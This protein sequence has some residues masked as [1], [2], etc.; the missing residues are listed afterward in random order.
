MKLPSLSVLRLSIYS[1]AVSTSVLAQD[2]PISE[3]IFA[4]LTPD[5]A[6]SP[7]DEHL[8]GDSIDFN[9]GNV[10]FSN[11]DLVAKGTGIDIVVSRSLVGT[12]VRYTYASSGN[13]KDWAINIPAVHVTTAWNSNND[14]SGSWGDS[15]ECSGDPRE[16]NF[17]EDN[18]SWSYAEYFNGVHLTLDTGS[19]EPVLL[20]N[21]SYLLGSGSARWVTKS[22]WKFSCGS[23]STGESFVGTAPNGLIYTFAKRVDVNPRILE[24]NNELITLKESRLL[25]TQITDRFNNTIT[26]NY[27]SN[28]NVT[29]ITAS[30]GRTITFS[31]SGAYVD[32]MTYNGRIWDYNYSTNSLTEVVQPDGTRYQYNLYDYYRYATPPSGSHACSDA[33]PSD[34]GVNVRTSSFTGTVTG[35]TGVTGTY[36]FARLKHGRANVDSTDT[37]SGS[38]VINPCFSNFGLTK[39]ILSI[40]GQGDKTWIYS[41]SQNAGFFAGYTPSSGQ[42]LNASNLPSGVDNEDYRMT[43]VTAP[44][45]TQ[46][47]YFYNRDFTSFN[48]G[49]L[50]ATQVYDNGGSIVQENI[51]TYTQSASFGDDLT[52]YDNDKPVRYRANTTKT[53]LERDNT[54][55]TTNYSSY[56]K[57]GNYAYKNEFMTGGNTKYWHYTFVNDTTNWLIGQEAKTEISQ[58]GSTYATA[59]KIGYYGATHTY[60][61]LPYITYRFGVYQRVN[62]AYHADGQLKS[63]TVNALSNNTSGSTAH[64]IYFFY[65]YHRG[66]P[67]RIRPYQLYESGV[68][69][70]AN[71]TVDDNGWVTQSKDFEGNIINYTYDDMGRVQTI[72]PVNSSWKDTL[73]DWDFNGSHPKLT[74]SRCT[75]NSAKTGCGGTASYQEVTTYDGLLNPELIART[76][77]VSSTTRYTNFI[78]DELSQKQFESFPSTSSTQSSGTTYTYDVLGR[79][80]TET[81]YG[82]GTVSYDYLSGNRTRV[83]DG[84]GNSTTTTYLAYGSPTKTHAMLIESPE[85]VNTTLTYNIYDNVT[86]ITQSGNHKSTSISITEQRAYNAQQRLCKV[87]RPDTGVSIYVYNNY[88]D[89]TYTAQGVTSSDATACSYS[90]AS[91]ASYTYDNL[92]L[93]HSIDY[94]DNTTPDVTYMRNKNGDLVTLESDSVIHNYTYNSA[95]LMTSEVLTVNSKTFTLSYGY[96]ALGHLSSMTYPGSTVGTVNFAPNGFGEPTKVTRSGQNYVTGATYYPDG[97]LNYFAYPNDMKHKQY[98]NSSQL[99]SQL[100]YYNSTQS[101]VYFSYTYDDNFN[102]DSLTDN[103]NNDYNLNSLSYDGLDRLI[104]VDGGNLI[105]DSTINYDALGNIEYYSSKSAAFTY[106]Y[107]LST[108]RLSDISGTGSGLY[109]FGANGSYDTRGNILKNGKRS[110]NYNRANQL[111]QSSTIS[112]QYDGHNRRVL[113]NNNGSIS[114]SMYSYNGQLIYRENSSGEGTSYIYL[115]NKLVAKDGLGNPV[116]SSIEPSVNISCNPSSCSKTATESVSITITLTASCVNSCESEWHYSDSFFAN[117]NGTNPKTFYLYCGS[118]DSTKTGTV[119]V[120]VTDSINGTYTTSP[121]KTVTLNCQSLGHGGGDEAL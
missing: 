50:I 44:N 86:A 117:D 77:V 47:R 19:S 18:I 94:D 22:N 36:T 4:R 1:V 82:G 69:N 26:Y 31:Y 30:D 45:G 101:K 35:P 54:L 5:F 17:Y 96:D 24:K 113:E 25:V 67:Q 109:N 33:D 105:G 116:S 15:Q 79:P 20:N 107:N 89:I 6:V 80:E 60:K 62:A 103:M 99:P 68:Y 92:G 29:L 57:Y 81:V 28:G 74:V 58:D 43:T 34:W 10:Q 2:A 71:V 112:F 115:G 63:F 27:D 108:N 3:E 14:V 61:G 118:S 65:N 76:D 85:S 93:L 91:G 111:T 106:T 42:L 90:N 121:T 37:A 41:Y 16:N 64:R 51:T 46:T 9:T 95:R 40:P 84:E 39:K 49:K 75:L 66:V 7:L 70:E 12:G 83:T 119:S 8:L 88:G 52:L 100:R 73:Y 98:Q 23:T 120:K 102:L 97:M 110:F 55:Y 59:S 21:T 38:P 104:S 72:D 13:L 87:T 114:Y 56:D 78:Y 11:T 53:Q 32:T 48:E